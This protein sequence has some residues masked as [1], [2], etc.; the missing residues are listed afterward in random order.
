MINCTVAI[1]GTVMKVYS[2]YTSMNRVFSD[3][4]VLPGGVWD[5]T[6]YETVRLGSAERPVTRFIHYIQYIQ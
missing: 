2:S 6:G 3:I 5:K 1:L 4:T